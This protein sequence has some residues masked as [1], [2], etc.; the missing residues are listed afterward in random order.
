MSDRSFSSDTHTTS[1]TF[2]SNWFQ[3][4]TIR[5]LCVKQGKI[6]QHRLHHQSLHVAHRGGPR[7][8]SQFISFDYNGVS[9]AK[10]S[11]NSVNIN[12][13]ARRAPFTTSQPLDEFC[14]AHDPIT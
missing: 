14:P 9:I 3:V 2:F 7:P 12:R 11:N 13:S 8:Q 10:D 5:P 1:R 6:A 4:S